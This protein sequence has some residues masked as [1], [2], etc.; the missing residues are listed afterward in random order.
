MVILLSKA[1]KKWQVLVPEFKNILTP[2]VPHFLLHCNSCS[3]TEF[4]KVKQQPLGPL[5]VKYQLPTPVN[6]P[7][8]PILPS[9]SQHSSRCTLEWLLG[10][11]ARLLVYSWHITRQRNWNS[12]LFIQFMCELDCSSWCLW[13]LSY[14]GKQAVRDA[15]VK[16]TPGMP[17]LMGNT[18]RRSHN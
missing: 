4:S 3:G 11:L 10:F 18:T 8:K 13:Q 9:V 17:Q 14:T 15:L 7:D 16:L 12:C 5:K 6:P 2:P 1:A